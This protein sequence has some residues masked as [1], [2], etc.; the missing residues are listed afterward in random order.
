L[1]ILLILG[2]FMEA[3]QIALFAVKHLPSEQIEANPRAKR[4]CDYILGTS[5]NN[6]DNNEEESSRLQA[7]LVGRQIA[8]TVIMFM[9]ARIITVEMKTPNTT[10]FGVS[11][12]I[13]TIFFD[14]GLLNALVS[15][16]FASLSWR[17][18]ANFFPMLYLGNPF[19][20]WIIRLC[21]VVEGTGICDAA[22]T[23]AKLPAYLIGYQKDTDYLTVIDVDPQ[24]SQQQQPQ[25]V[26]G[27]C[28]SFTSSE[29]SEKDEDVEQ[30]TSTGGNTGKK[31]PKNV[32]IVNGDDEC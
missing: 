19:S 18:T 14:S 21:L 29:S 32:T 15:T 5:N 24:Q 28:S 13:Q 20:I 12:Q 2:G 4:N 10:L 25:V 27:G 31:A 7:F 17:V 23:L 6:N 30:G 26:L 11:P 22:W 9:I 3:L 16:I 1:L 8:Q